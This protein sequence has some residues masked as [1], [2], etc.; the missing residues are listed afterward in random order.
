MDRTLYERDFALWLQ[1]TARAIAER[2]FDAVDWDN[3]LEE[4][5]STRKSERKELKS[6]LI[7]LI[8][9]LLKL[10]YWNAEREDNARGWYGT[11][12]EQR[13]QIQLCLEDSPPLR[14]FF[15]EVFPDCYRN[16]L[17][18]TRRKYRL[19]PDIFPESAPFTLEEAIDP[20]F[21]P[22]APG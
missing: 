15:Q 11:I 18:D 16:A 17:E 12:V 13:R 9:H 14:P 6:R 19:S 20:D 4:L 8:E 3:L 1:S 22:D 7:L 10:L 21:P 5:D 2:R